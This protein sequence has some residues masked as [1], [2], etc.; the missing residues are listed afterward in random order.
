MINFMDTVNGLPAAPH[1][2]TR[3]RNRRELILTAAGELFVQK[4][5]P[6]VGMT[7]VAKVMA[8]QPSA[9]YRHFSSKSELLREVVVANFQPILDSVERT[10]GGNHAELIDP[11]THAAFKY[12]EDGVLW[13]RESRHLPPS[14]RQQISDRERSRSA[15]SCNWGTLN[16]RPWKPTCGHGR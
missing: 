13:Q 10:A 4:G 9:L 5:Y 14:V 7:D 2:G 3:P 1:R 15:T 8:V 11:L 12:Q 6:Q 16:S